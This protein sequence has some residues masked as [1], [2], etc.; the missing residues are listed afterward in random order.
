VARQLQDAGI[1]NVDVEDVRVDGRKFWRV[2]VGPLAA[3]AAEEV[4]RTV[5]GLGL[6]SP[7][8]FSE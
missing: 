6:P 7:R 3:A 2:R 8:V 4:A 5:V 1:R